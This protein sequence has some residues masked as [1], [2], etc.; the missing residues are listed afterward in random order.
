V[1]VHI[2]HAMTIHGF[3]V[4]IAR[5]RRSGAKYKSNHALE[6][7]ILCLPSFADSKPGHTLEKN[8]EI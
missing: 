7:L 2:P 5:A 1:P 3:N 4:T 8:V 6:T